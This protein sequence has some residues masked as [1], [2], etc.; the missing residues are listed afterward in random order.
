MDIVELFE[1]VGLEGVEMSMVKL[2]CT[3]V[4]VWQELNR[5]YNPHLPDLCAMLYI[6]FLGTLDR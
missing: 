5:L 4:R 3:Y 1:L 2:K 6:H